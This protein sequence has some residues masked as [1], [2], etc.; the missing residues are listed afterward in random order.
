MPDVIYIIYALLEGIVQGITEWLPISST[1][2]LIILDGL[3]AGLI[4]PSVLTDEFKETFDVVIQLGSIA[5]V[6]VLYFNRLDPFSRSK[7]KSEKKET[8]R[9]WAKVFVAAVPAGII[10]SMFD[11]VLSRTVFTKPYVYYV[12]A[13]SLFIWGVLFIVAERINKR[14]GDL[15]R[16]IDLRCAFGI[17]L[18]QI[19]ALIP[20]T[21]RSGSTILG[22]TLMGVPRVAAAEFS[23]FLAI[24]V[25]VGASGLKIVKFISS[26][27]GKMMSSAQI[28]VLLT[29]CVTAFLVSIAAVRFLVGFV[30]RHS[31]EG[32]GRYRIALALLVMIRFSVIG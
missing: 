6:V 16:D 28:T 15:T 32:F 17:G 29:G 18:F 7:S 26:S 22:A 21:S 8:L 14:R 9:L 25:M 20:G 2:H 13:A 23:F 27:G 5:A 19:F 4:D 1:G 12:T 31:F 3:L 11:D 10:G 30:R 24:P